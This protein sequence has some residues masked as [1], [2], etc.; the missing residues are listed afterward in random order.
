MMRITRRPKKAA[1][2]YYGKYESTRSRRRNGYG[3][4]E[5]VQRERITLYG[6]KF[7]IRFNNIV[8]ETYVICAIHV[9]P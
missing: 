9:C 1:R 8:R 2:R 5:D 7:L 6:K 4:R 3:Y